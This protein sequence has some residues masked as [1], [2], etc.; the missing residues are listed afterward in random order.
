[1]GSLINQI[2]ALLM[3][4]Y[5]NMNNELAIEVIK[6]DLETDKLFRENFSVLTNLMKTDNSLIEICSYLIDI[7]RN[8]HSISRQIRGIAQELVFLF[9]A[10]MIKHQSVV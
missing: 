7:N 10:K 4:S 3:D 8:I 2:T 9:E 1:M 6:K 5:V